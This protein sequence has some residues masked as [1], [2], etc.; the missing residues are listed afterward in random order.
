ML[1]SLWNPFGVNEL[2]GVSLPRVA[3]QA[4]Q[5]WALLCIPF[6]EKNYI[7][8][9]SEGVSGYCLP[10]SSRHS[11]HRSVAA[12]DHVGKRNSNPDSSNRPGTKRRLFRINSVS[13]R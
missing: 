8:G 7:G 9:T 4:T 12:S 2:G 1:R 13:V 10:R 6:G 3:S 11:R 5:P